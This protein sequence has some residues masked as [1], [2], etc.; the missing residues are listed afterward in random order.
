VS[1]RT[2]AV[3]SSLSFDDDDRIVLHSAQRVAEGIKF[4]TQHEEHCQGDEED[5]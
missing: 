5:I 4:S 3:C 2:S 1:G